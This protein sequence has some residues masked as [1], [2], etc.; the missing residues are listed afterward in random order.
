MNSKKAHEQLKK[1]NAQRNAI[2]VGG[3]KD[4]RRSKCDRHDKFNTAITEMNTASD[5]LKMEDLENE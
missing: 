1:I 3:F 4:S 5:K 2:G